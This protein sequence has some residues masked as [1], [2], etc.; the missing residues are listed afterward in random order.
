[1]EEITVIEVPTRQVVGIK[2]RGSYHLIP[3]LLMQLAGYIIEKKITFAGMPMFICHET[4][5]ECVKEANENGTA[6]VEVVWPVAGTVTGSG[7]IEVYP[8]PGG[9]M[10]RTVHKGPYETCES[11]YLALFSWIEHHH[12]QIAGPIREIYPNDPRE[13]KPEEILTEILVPIR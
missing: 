11:T 13:V 6:L 1:M 10:V 3:E 12:L 2:K 5:P 8:L 4:S 9:K 7:V